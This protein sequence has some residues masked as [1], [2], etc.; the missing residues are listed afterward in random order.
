M[1]AIFSHFSAHRNRRKEGEKYAGKGG[2]TLTKGVRGSE[3][4][5]EAENGRNR[6]KIGSKTGFWK[7]SR[8]LNLYVFS[9]ISEDP[10]KRRFSGA[11]ARENGRKTTKNGEIGTCG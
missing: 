9:I 4:A 2:K 8:T 1:I 6:A 10:R 3:T 7:M 5:I 11:C